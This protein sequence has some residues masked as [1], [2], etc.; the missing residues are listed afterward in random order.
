MNIMYPR[1]QHFVG[2]NGRGHCGGLHVLT[3]HEGWPESCPRYVTLYPLTSKGQVAHCDIEIP[4]ESLP[5][6]IAALQI[7]LPRRAVRRRRGGVG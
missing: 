4:V 3:P 5:Q 1:L 6:V 2:R 7:A